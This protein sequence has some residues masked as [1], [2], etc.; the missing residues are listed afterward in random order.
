MRT[1]FAVAVGLVLAAG[2][3]MA[4]P[5]P[6]VGKPTAE[7]VKAAEKAL[8]EYLQKKNALRGQH[9]QL[10]DEAVERTLPGYV[11]FTLLFRQYPVGIA[12][13]P[14]FGVSSV[15]AVDRKGEV[16]LLKDSGEL[17]KFLKANLP[18]VSKD[19][20]ARD[21]VRSYLKIAQEFR[22]DGFYKFELMDGSVK[23][24]GDKG[25]TAAG[26]VV[27]MQ[28]GNG[29]LDAKLEFDQAGKLVKAE[30]TATI[31][32]GPR[33]ICQ[34]TKLLDPDPI[35]RKMAE[36]DLRCMGRFAREYLMEQRAKSSPELREAID[37][38]WKEI[39]K[40]DR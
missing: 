16:T 28:G 18:D 15:L 20:Q 25:K 13:A 30:E 1:L 38:I 31:K 22:Q 33:P 29:A 40:D 7:D 21:A 12:P 8:L 32:P 34:A 11:F 19:D 36:Q 3:V 2:P 5:V 4:A 24:G 6:P 26:K 23:V 37:R 27:V 17:E 39:E 14:G 35:V 10:K 9:A